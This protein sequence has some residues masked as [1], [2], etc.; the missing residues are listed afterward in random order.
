MIK[1][2]AEEISVNVTKDAEQY[3]IC[4]YGYQIFFEF[5]I[6][7]VTC[8]VLA[9]I[10]GVLSAACCF[11]ATLFI[12]R[13][14]CGGIHLNKFWKCYILSCITILFGGILASR[15][16]FN[17]ESAFVLGVF[18]IIAIELLLGIR[19]RNKYFEFTFHRRIVLLAILIILIILIHIRKNVMFTAIAVALQ[20]A[21]ISL[22]LEHSNR[23]I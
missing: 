9:I 15:Q 11:A 20:I 19:Y 10:C 21:N 18:N 3:E 1:K 17:G 8:A 6:C 12:V 23:N 22:L 14:F 7:V 4:K 5:L 13:T 16:P 2:I